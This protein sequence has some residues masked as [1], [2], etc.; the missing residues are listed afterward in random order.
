MGNG[1]QIPTGVGFGVIG[2]DRGRAFSHYLG[3]HGRQDGTT[4]WRIWSSR[5]HVASSP[6]QGLSPLGLNTC[7]HPCASSVF[8]V[9]PVNV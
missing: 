6:V 3:E 5:H 4:I 7:V 1:S 9:D 8:T 2:N